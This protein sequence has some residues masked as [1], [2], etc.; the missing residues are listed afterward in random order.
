MPDGGDL[1]TYGVG[2]ASDITGVGGALNGAGRAATGVDGA[3]TI[4][5]AGA[6]AMTVCENVP[7]TVTA[8]FARPVLEP[9][10]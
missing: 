2:A 5:E 10:P 7:L 6:G 8:V 9:S 1:L 4:R 3:V